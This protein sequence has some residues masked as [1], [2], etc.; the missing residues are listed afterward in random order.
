MTALEKEAIRDRLIA[1]GWSVHI[2]TGEADVCI[3]RNAE[4]TQDPNFATLTRDSDLPMHRPVTKVLMPAKGG[5]ELISRE[6]VLRAFQM[7]EDQLQLLAVVSTS[8]Y[9]KS[10][11]HY[12]L[13]KN[14]KAIRRRTVGAT[15]TSNSWSIFVDL[16]ETPAPAGPE[17]A[18]PQRPNRESMY[19]MLQAKRIYISKMPRAPQPT[20]RRLRRRTSY[21]VRP[22]QW[23]QVVNNAPV[24]V[25][26]P[27]K[28]PLDGSNN[29]GKK[30][31]KEDDDDTVPRFRISARAA[32]NRE[33]GMEG[34][35]TSVPSVGSSTGHAL[36]QAAQGG[37][38]GQQDEVADEM[39]VTREE[40]KAI[41]EDMAPKQDDTVMNVQQPTL[42]AVTTGV[43]QPSAVA[44]LEL[45]S[46][47]KLLRQNLAPRIAAKSLE[48]RGKLHV[49]LRQYDIA[50][51]WNYIHSEIVHN[52]EMSVNARG[53][54]L[55][56]WN[57]YNLL[58]LD[59]QAL[60]RIDPAVRGELEAAY[61]NPR[62]HSDMLDANPRERAATEALCE[63]HIRNIPRIAQITAGYLQSIVH[64]MSR[65]YHWIH[66]ALCLF[67]A[68]IVWDQSQ[69]KTQQQMDQDQEDLRAILH[70]TRGRNIVRW[71]GNYLS[72]MDSSIALDRKIMDRG[73]V[74]RIALAAAA[75]LRACCPDLVLPPF[76][77]GH[78]EIYAD[79]TETLS[80]KFAEFFTASLSALQE[81][82]QTKTE[83]L[84]GNNAI[85]QYMALNTARREQERWSFF[86]P[87]PAM[88]DR[89]INF[90]SKGLRDALM[91]T[92]CPTRSTMALLFTANEELP[93]ELFFEGTRHRKVTMSMQE[94][95]ADE[96]GLHTNL[97]RQWDER[98][99]RQAAN[100]D[101]ERGPRKQKARRPKRYKVTSGAIMT[102]GLVV[103]GLVFDTSQR[104]PGP[105]KAGS[106]P[107]I[108]VP[109]LGG[110]KELDANVQA[111]L[112]AHQG[113]LHI[114]GLDPGEVITCACTTLPP[115]PQ[116]KTAT[117]SLV[118]RPSL[119]QATSNFNR[120]LQARKA[121]KTILNDVAYP[122]I[123]E[124][125]ALTPHRS[126]IGLGPLQQNIK[127]YSAFKRMLNSLYCCPWYK[128]RQ[129]ERTKQVRGNYERA[130]DAILRSASA[131]GPG[132]A[133]ARVPAMQV[134]PNTG[135]SMNLAIVIGDGEFAS[136]IG[137]SSRHR[138]LTAFIVKKVSLG[139]LH[140]MMG[141]L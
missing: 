41:L 24:A 108:G 67:V 61:F 83:D 40:A 19:N 14:H 1:L 106:S 8:D 86:F 131:T 13:V 103:H 28:R 37:V 138:T 68:S 45:G 10:V 52:P 80:D 17:V 104:K 87:R 72:G 125:E 54:L 97:K 100:E 47:E 105:V 3:A 48:L 75:L 128:R 18:A 16:T 91:S 53:L 140:Q 77:A 127:W 20:Q 62:V 32:R 132:S 23:T 102:N 126:M 134:D 109:L 74:Q 42:T 69:Q 79:M 12:G 84:S 78:R 63:G 43:A 57:G 2:C 59:L 101:V 93:Q 117:N 118:S 96:D 27:P 55:E 65:W 107:L 115:S 136:G 5:L 38:Q 95:C 30:K 122:S 94:Y 4:D 56:R 73:R 60:D 36:Q 99:Q 123:N 82:T 51:K 85:T 124:I 70:P 89:W 44:T 15:D 11:P 9:C 21:G 26:R 141:K 31:K 35:S 71:T 46:L 76:P 88:G 110:K 114:A 64:D 135:Y 113:T 129:W 34:P 139:Q 90:S 7:D 58:I 111:H 137:R 81:E 112:D 66:H 49:A 130:F 98:S 29:K 6:D 121:E 116:V 119:Y 22:V 39:T 33:Y 120:K 50:I 92:D 25:T 133:T